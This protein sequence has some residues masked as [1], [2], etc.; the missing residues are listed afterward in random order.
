M[1]KA[2]ATKIGNARIAPYPESKSTKR[3]HS[4]PNIDKENFNASSKPSAKSTK[5]AVE[6]Q[7][8]YSDYRD[9]EL[10][11]I[12][13]EIPYYDDATTVR[14]KLKKL[15]TDKSNIPSTNKS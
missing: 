4:K 6:A 3:D 12:L 1:P 10:E 9:I 7:Q 15:L 13:G 14:R 5:A 8:H 2:L 11:E